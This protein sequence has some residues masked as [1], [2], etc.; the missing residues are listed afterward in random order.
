[1]ERVRSSTGIQFEALGCMMWERQYI[2]HAE[3][4]AGGKLSEEAALSNW[5]T[6]TEMVQRDPN[7]LIWDQKGPTGKTLRF[8]VKEKDVVKFT[9]G[10]EHEK[11]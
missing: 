8:W 3:T 2:E 7:C 9:N 4:T 10:Y 1:M 6:W 5:K 11:I